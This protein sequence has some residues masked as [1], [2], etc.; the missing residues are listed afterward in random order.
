[1]NMFGMGGPLTLPMSM[2]NVAQNTVK[3]TKLK[4]LAAI[5]QMQDLLQDLAVD[6]DLSETFSPN[7]SIGAT[8]QLSLALQK[9]DFGS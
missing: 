3:N 7:L 1:M 5:N 8:S 9:S 2:N 4:N 6:Q